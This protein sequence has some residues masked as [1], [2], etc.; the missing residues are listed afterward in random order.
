MYD[1]YLTLWNVLKIVSVTS[2]IIFVL[3]V[4]IVVMFFVWGFFINQFRPLPHAR[5]GDDALR[6]KGI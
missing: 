6:R 4:F 2:L 5:D 1:V 3:S